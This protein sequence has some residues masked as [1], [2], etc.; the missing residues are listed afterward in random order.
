M[1]KNES[2]T[3]LFLHGNFIVKD[4]GNYFI[5][6]LDRNAMVTNVTLTGSLLSKATQNEVYILIICVFYFFQ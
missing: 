3:T 4:I 2:V 1:S 6:Y 5:G